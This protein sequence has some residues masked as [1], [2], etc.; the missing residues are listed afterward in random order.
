MENLKT[1]KV[2]TPTSDAVSVHVGLGDVPKFAAYSYVEALR[3]NFIT[4]GA[5]GAFEFT[6]KVTVSDESVS[7]TF[8]GAELLTFVKKINLLT[9]GQ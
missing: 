1:Y 3:R 8:D 9:E 4:S 2:F 6:S 7:E 5:S